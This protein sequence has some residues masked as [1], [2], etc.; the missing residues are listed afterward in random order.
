MVKPRCDLRQ[1]LL[2]EYSFRLEVGG[3]GNYW[4]RVQSYEKQKQAIEQ[5][6]VKWDR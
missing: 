5:M 4:N 3:D 2:F 1:S 6:R